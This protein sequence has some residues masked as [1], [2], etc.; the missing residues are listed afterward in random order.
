MNKPDTNNNVKL[1]SFLGNRKIILGVT[2]LIIALAT[3]CVSSF[4]PYMFKP[5]NLRSY[6]FITD[7]VINC[8]IVILAMVSTIFIGQASNAQ[9]PKSNIAKAIVKFRESLELVKQ[10]GIRKF[11]LWIKKVQQPS[12]IQEIKNEILFEHGIEDPTI[13]NLTIADVKSLVSGP[14][15]FNK[16]PYPSITEEQAEVII[17][18]KTKGI[19]VKLVPPEYY[20]N[21]KNLTDSRT[22]T[23]R[24]ANEGVKKASKLLVSVGS[25]LVLTIV[26]SSIFAMLAK[27]LTQSVSKLDAIVTLFFRLLN[28]FTS[29]FMGYLVGCQIND[30]DSEYITMREEVH[31][32]F[33]EDKEFVVKSVKEEA[34]E[35]IQA[36]SPPEPDKQ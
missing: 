24:A 30:L 1:R 11:K 12:D 29:V 8:A 9:N 14:K 3:I 17:K 20:V 34:L 25:K 2:A 5:E 28:F 27:D 33:L 31:R 36:N 21:V 22:K 10:E 16:I 19:R 23:Q 4:V 15:E 13:L 6:K 26:F 7:L 32:E 18:L 35:E